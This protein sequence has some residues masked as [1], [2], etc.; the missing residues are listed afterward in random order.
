M[1]PQKLSENRF[2]S[3]I[4]SN[5]K[6]TTFNI[7]DKFGISKQV[8]LENNVFNFLE[9]G[10]TV[11]F[12]GEGNILDSIALNNLE[13]LD[14]SKD[15]Y[16]DD[17][18]RF[19]IKIK[20]EVNSGVKFETKVFETLYKNL[21]KEIETVLEERFKVI[22][23]DYNKN[24]IEILEEEEWILEVTDGKVFATKNIYFM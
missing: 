3:D 21:F 11:E 4:K 13:L 24:K 14:V 19:A 23:L 12:F 15:Y 5:S 1:L 10:K 2:I 17:P 20:S 7:N 8:R 18:E 9:R 6:Y 22:G 16:E